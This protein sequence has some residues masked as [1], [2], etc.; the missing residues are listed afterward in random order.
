MDWHYT[1]YIMLLIV[2]AM[3]SAM[4]AVYAWQH[5]RVPG[6][7]ALAWLMSAVAE[8]SLA[9]VP[10][11]TSADLSA[12]IFWS[13]VKYVGICLVPFVWLIYVLQYTGR[14]KWLTRR[15]VAL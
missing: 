10:A 1:P 2:S 3:T 15:N 5:R 7:S 14:E 13:D 11:L 12:K 4:L 6:A 9:S 8:W